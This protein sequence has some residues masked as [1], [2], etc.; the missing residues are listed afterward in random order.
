[1]P[2]KILFLDFDGV[3]H[4][5]PVYRHPKGGMY[6]GV[7]CAGHKLFENAEILVNA[8][9]SYPDVSIVLTTS[10][11]RVLGFARA[12]AHLPESLRRRVVGATFHSTMNKF[13]FDAMSR[14]AQAL[15]D[16]TRRRATA[17]VALDDDDG[18]LSA[19]ESH[20]VKT[21]RVLGISASQ[22]QHEMLGK[23]HVQFGRD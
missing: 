2:S 9:A 11:V 20:V 21:D 1:M 12:K 15:A 13:E 8:L 4:P 14:G 10:W 16:A 3:L 6:F 5:E 19:A 22:V 23:F 17:W 7:E 18:W